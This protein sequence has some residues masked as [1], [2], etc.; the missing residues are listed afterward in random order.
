MIWTIY[1]IIFMYPNNKN[2]WCLREP[3]TIL[4][5]KGEVTQNGPT[6][7]P[8]YH[9]QIELRRGNTESCNSSARFQTTFLRPPVFF[10]LKFEELGRIE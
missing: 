1:F 9:K 4:G 6:C 2:A 10:K 3:G 8:K 5:V 7:P